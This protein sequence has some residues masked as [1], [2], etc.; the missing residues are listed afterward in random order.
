MKPDSVVLMGDYLIILGFRDF[1]AHL[2]AVDLRDFRVQKVQLVKW[3]G[4]RFYQ[5]S[6]YDE[7]SLLQKYGENQIIVFDKIHGLQLIVIESFQRKISLV[8]IVV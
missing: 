8:L 7:L 5:D 6:S 2:L 4:D 3:K 1:F